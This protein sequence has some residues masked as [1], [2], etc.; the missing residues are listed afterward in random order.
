ML[1]GKDMPGLK[2]LQTGGSKIKVSYLALPDGADA[3]AE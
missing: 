1:H 2:E 3:K